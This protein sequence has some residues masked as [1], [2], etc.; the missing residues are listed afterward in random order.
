MFCLVYGQATAPQ[1]ASDI[2]LAL[3][4]LFCHPEWSMDVGGYLQKSV[5]VPEL[6]WRSFHSGIILGIVR[7]QMD[8]RAAKA[9]TCERACTI[10]AYVAR[11]PEQRFVSRTDTRS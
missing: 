1:Y 5:L 11:S 2:A 4:A 7:V 9:L 8:T 10:E 3:S 6:W